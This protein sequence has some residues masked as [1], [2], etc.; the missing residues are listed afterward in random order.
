MQN[1]SFNSQVP[2]CFTKNACYLHKCLELC[3]FAGSPDDITKLSNRGVFSQV[4]KETAARIDQSCLEK[5]NE[6][7]NV[8]SRS[9]LKRMSTKMLGLG[10]WVR[11]YRQLITQTRYSGLE[12]DKNQFKRKCNTEP[13]IERK[14]LDKLSK[15]SPRHP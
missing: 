14:E 9:Q 2:A 3:K 10:K 13:L 12:K 1:Q 15:K 7:I 8:V 4:K 6:L 11:V 5:M